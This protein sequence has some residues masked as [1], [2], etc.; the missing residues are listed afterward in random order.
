MKIPIFVLSALLLIA[1]AGAT[2]AIAHHATSTNVADSAMQQEMEKHQVMESIDAFPNYHPLVVHFPIVLLLMAMLF[3]GLSFFVYKKEFSLAAM[4]LLFLGVI[5]TWLSSNTFHAHPGPLTGKANEIYATHEQMA[6]FTWWFSLAA[7]LIKIAS[8]FFLDRGWWTETL[9]VVFLIAASVTV[10]IAGHHGAML[11]HM[12]G[13]GPM[14]KYLESEMKAS[15]SASTRPIPKTAA[16]EAPSTNLTTT[17]GEEPDHHVGEFGKG[18]HGG[19]IEEA[20]P[21]HIEILANGGDLVFFLLDGDAEPVSMKDVTG[22]IRRTSLNKSG[23]SM[24]LMQMGGKLTAMDANSNA[25]YKIICTLT[26]AGK[27]YSATFE[28]KKDLHV[29]EVHK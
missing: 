17:P 21:Y 29:P 12:E 28:S 15:N 4:I 23:A 9:A 18:P 8:H 2:T 25:P 1:I 13:I 3:Q 20:D 6:N 16:K 11:V 24:D 22:E 19:T 26:K 27:Q 5:A 14:G 10:S 7:L